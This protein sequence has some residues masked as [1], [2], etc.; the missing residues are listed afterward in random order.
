MRAPAS[1]TVS[2]VGGVPSGG[3]AVTI[4]TPDG[5]A[6]TLLQLGSTAVA[7]DAT[8]EVGAAGRH[9][10]R[11]RRWRHDG[12]ARPP[13]C[14]RV[15][16]SERLPRPAR[17][18][19]VTPGDA[20]AAGAR[21]RPVAGAGR[22]APR[23]PRH[24]QRS[25]RC[26]WLATAAAQEPVPTPAPAATSSSPPVQT[27]SAAAAPHPAAPGRHPQPT[28]TGAPS[29]A[30]PRPDVLGACLAHVPRCSRRRRAVTEGGSDSASP[31]R[32]ASRSVV[33]V[34]VGSARDVD[35]AG[36]R[37]RR[38]RHRREVGRLG[39][40]G[41]R[42]SG[43]RSRSDVGAVGRGGARTDRVA[44]GRPRAPSC[45]MPRSRGPPQRSTRDRPSPWPEALVVLAAG[46]ACV[47]SAV[48]RRR[49]ARDGGS[50]SRSYHA[51]P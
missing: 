16:R 26:R 27:A 36:R 49:R 2:F 20:R 40:C 29:S 14:S 8:V 48:A 39:G 23:P 6:V 34:V 1:G 37:A 35:A 5:L 51:R 4:L 43:A 3:R 46:C 45:G 28:T 10:R 7:T 22:R 41:H 19:A 31:P 11:E 30:A 44:E 21:R 25:P 47:A 42:R 12:T 32:T 18:P 24:L 9:R 15:R 38:S 13:R 17:V 33:A 50:G